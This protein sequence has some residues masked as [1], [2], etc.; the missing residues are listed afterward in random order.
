MREQIAEAALVEFHER[1]YHACGVKDITDAAGVPKGSLYN[2]WESKEALAVEA[3]RRY[4]ATRRHDMLLDESK[5]P[6]ARLR[7]HFEYLV[8]QH[9]HSGFRRGCLMGNFA[10]ELS[11]D[12]PAL[13]EAIRR[14]FASWSTRVEALLAEAQER[15]EIDPSLDVARHARFLI[16]SWQ[17]AVLR[18]RVTKDREPLEDFLALALPDEEA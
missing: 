16:S 6:L 13:T 4:G 12:S 2:H 17:G 11:D 9:E 14:R 8:G 15:G 3:L 1:G 18:A 7:G 5:P 10:S